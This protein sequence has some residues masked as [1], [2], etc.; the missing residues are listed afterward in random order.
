MNANKTNL[1][2][3]N[4]NTLISLVAFKCWPLVILSYLYEMS[5]VFTKVIFWWIG[6]FF[7]SLMATVSL[8]AHTLDSVKCWNS[9]SGIQTKFDHCIALHCN[10]CS[11]FLNKCSNGLANI[12]HNFRKRIDK[13]VKNGSCSPTPNITKEHVFKSISWHFTLMQVWP[14]WCI[15]MFVKD[16][17]KNQR[18]IFD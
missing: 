4:W 8:D 18:S 16:M 6:M 3:F 2:W 12:W 1:V 5:L 7:I 11:Y 17:K 9:R 10:E 15:I 14:F 13:Y